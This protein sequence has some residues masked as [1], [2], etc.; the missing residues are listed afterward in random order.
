MALNYKPLWILLAKKSL[1]KTDVIVMAGITTNVMAQMGKN[2]PI[3]L[4]NLE[5]ICK[6]LDC[7]PNDVFSFDD[8]YIE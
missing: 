3:T 7:T 2:K 5:K 4:K 8:N 6:A 1:K